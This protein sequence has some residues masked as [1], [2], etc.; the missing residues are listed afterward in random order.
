MFW[1]RNNFETVAIIKSRISNKSHAVWYGDAG[2]TGA[3]IESIMSNRCH[4][5]ANVYGC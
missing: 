4:A 1:N 5:F 3:T 2:E